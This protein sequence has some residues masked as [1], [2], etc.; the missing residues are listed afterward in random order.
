MTGEGANAQGQLASTLSAEP[1]DNYGG[2]AAG[3]E[4]ADAIRVRLWYGIPDISLVR[5]NGGEINP[6]H[7][8]GGELV[9]VFCPV[10]SAAAGA[11]VRAYREL[12][13]AFG[14]SGA[15]L[16][17]LIDDAQLADE[18]IVDRGLLLARDPGGTG[19]SA[20][21]AL[22]PWLT[23]ADRASGGTFYFGRGGSLVRFWPGAGH[24]SDALEA[25]VKRR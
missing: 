6:A 5:L 18:D 19:W 20:F 2:G 9:V 14:E 11:E 15:W 12:A 3:E 25:I 22:V 7:F 24:A 21:S 16:I 1:R 13:N 8:I 10:D 4:R 17:G 23:G